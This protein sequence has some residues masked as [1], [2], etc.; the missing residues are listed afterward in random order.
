MGVVVFDADVLIAHLNADDSQHQAAVKRVAQALENRDRRLLSA[1][2]YT[3]VLVGPFARGHDSAARAKTALR[4]LG[5]EPIPVDEKLAAR[6]AQVR[7]R[8][9]L[10]LPDAYAVATALDTRADAEVRLES[11]DKQ[12]TRVFAELRATGL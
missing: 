2:N 1:V 3:E 12:V 11:L 4:M 7:A 10:K 6:A 8:T 9:K 5:I